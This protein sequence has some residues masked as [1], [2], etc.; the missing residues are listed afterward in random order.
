MLF[1]SLLFVLFD[2]EIVFLF[3]WAIIYDSFGWNGFFEGVGFIGILCLG[4]LYAWRKG[5]LEWR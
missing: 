4:I 3:P 5:A 2:V 1:R